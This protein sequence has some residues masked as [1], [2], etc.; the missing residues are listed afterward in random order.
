MQAMQRRAFLAAGSAALFTAAAPRAWAAFPDKP[1]KLIVPWAAG[2]STDAIA[3]AMAQRMSQTIGSSVIVDNRPGA[4]GQIGTEAAAK[5]APDGY[6]L[7]IVELPHAIAPAVTMRLPYDLLRDFTPV[8]MIG[9]SPLVFFAGMDDDSR[10]FKTF[11]K[12]AASRPMPPAI[13]HSGAGTVSHLA[14]ELLASRTK[15]KFN[16]VPYRGSAPALTDVAAGTVAGHFATLAS[17]SSLVGGNRIRPLLVTSAQRVN[18]PGLKD[19]PGLAESGLKG[20]EIDQWWAMVAPATTP[21]EV[22]ER[23]RREAIAALDHPSVKE[24]MAVLGVQLKGSTTGELRA[25]MRAEAERWQK[26]AHDIGLQPQ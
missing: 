3:R 4:A 20:L 13:A 19:V 14:A 17:G 7:S 15:I 11:I 6:T 26:V 18:I 12:T 5:A 24:R 9:T 16:M 23:L 22:I 25:F 10:D 8:T 2:G 21:L 1:I